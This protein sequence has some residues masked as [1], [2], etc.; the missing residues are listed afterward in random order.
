MAD[1]DE[2]SVGACGLDCASCEI[3]TFPVDQA[4][5]RVVVAWFKKKGW[6]NKDEGVSEA[7]ERKMV[8]HG[9]LGDRTAHWSADCWILQCCVDEKGLQSCAQC[10]SFPCERLSAWSRKDPSYDH[11]LKRLR[12]IR[13]RHHRESSS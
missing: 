1:P 2:I 5:A 10:A 7:L 11:A 8:C 4:A 13:S 6:L 9:C 12:A 3:R